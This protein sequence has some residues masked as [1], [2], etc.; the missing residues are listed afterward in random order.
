MNFLAHL[1]LADR[2]GTSLAGAVLGDVVRGT[3]LSAYPE[4]LA[5]GIRLHRRVDAATDRHPLIVQMRAGF[6]D[7]QRRYAGIVLDL[8]L[9]H[10]LALDW[11]QHHTQPLDAF[12]AHAAVQ[13]ASASNWFIRAGGRATDADAFTR[14][15][16]SYAHAEGIERALARVAARLRRP[17]ALL[18]TAASWQARLPALRAHLPRLLSEVADAATRS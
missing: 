16:L 15:L 6:A 7:G 3:D 5:Q 1:W 9:D 17:E 10:A 11:A 14:L 2:T 8:A 4:A 18:S 13:I 12:C